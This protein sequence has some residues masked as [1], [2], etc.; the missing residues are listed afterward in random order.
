MLRRSSQSL[1]REAAVFLIDA[2]CEGDICGGLSKQMAQSLS[3][4][5]AFLSIL[6]KKAARNIQAQL[7][8]P[9]V[10]RLRARASSAGA[11]LDGETGVIG[12]A[13]TASPPSPPRASGLS[14]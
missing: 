5:P 11:G 1:V 3:L 8:R 13:D 12:S 7:S 6:E 9:R 14:R 4:L 2:K 10:A